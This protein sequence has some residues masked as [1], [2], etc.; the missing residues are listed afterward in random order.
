[1]TMSTLAFSIDLQGSYA[2][3][4]KIRG[5]IFGN[6]HVKHKKTKKEGVNKVNYHI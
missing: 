6:V 5:S 4:I 2:Y 3:A 1:M